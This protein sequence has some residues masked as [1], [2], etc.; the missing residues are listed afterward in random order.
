MDI[1]ARFLFFMVA[2]ILAG[3]FY[4]LLNMICDG[5]G[6]IATELRHTVE[7]FSHSHTQSSY[8][9]SIIAPLGD[10]YASDRA[11]IVDGAISFH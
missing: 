7:F 11:K 4:A 5:V 10:K 2:S 9:C 3:I 6:E 8:G 1:I